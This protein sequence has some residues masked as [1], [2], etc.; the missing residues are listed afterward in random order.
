LIGEMQRGRPQALGVLFDRYY[1]LVFQIARK[2]LR[3]DGEA[4]DLLQEVFLEVHRKADLYDPSRGS[5]NIWLLQFAYHRGFN[6]RKYLA[7][8]SF[9]DASPAAAL[10]DR[11]LAGE[12]GGRQGLSTQ[13]W[14]Q[15]LE[16]GMDELNDKERQIIESVAFDGVREASERVRE[17]Y[18]NG[19]NHYY[20]GL[21][22]LRGILAPRR[23]VNDVRS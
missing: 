7:L 18:V 13:E 10:A 9:C 15:V 17:S 16:R 12:W 23:E 11:E 22:K 21:R 6:R 4:E 19:R 1:R 8:R 3:D 5:V 2:I 14:R 20:R